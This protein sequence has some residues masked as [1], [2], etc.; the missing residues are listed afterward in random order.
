M[1]VENRAIKFIRFSDGSIVVSG[2]TVYGLVPLIAFP[3]R[4]AFGGFID[5]CIDFKEEGEVPGVYKEAFK[6]LA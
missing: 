3:S 1:E 4:E 2:V 5:D 6:D